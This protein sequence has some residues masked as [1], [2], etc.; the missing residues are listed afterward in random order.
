M[1]STSSG[2]WNG[3]TCWVAEP[4]AT[5]LL[6]SPYPPD[7]VWKQLPTQV[8]RRILEKSLRF[9]RRDALAVASEAGLGGRIN[10]VMHTC[11][12]A[13][14][15]VLPRDEAIAKIRRRSGRPTAA[16]GGRAE[17]NFAAVDGSLA[18]CTRWLS[19]CR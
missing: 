1:A 16:R 4:G 8:Q 10:T 9:P 2:S 12:F 14:S 15:G 13:L 7:H 6:N 3:P 17:R 19:R 5:F 11:F 18:A